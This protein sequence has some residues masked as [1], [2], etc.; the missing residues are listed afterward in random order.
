MITDIGKQLNLPSGMR[1]ITTSIATG[2]SRR[3]SETYAVRQ[4][5][6]HLFGTGSILGHRDDGSPVIA[7]SKTEISVSHSRTHAFLASHPDL[8]I[9]VD[10]EL[11]RQQLAIVARK[12]LSDEELTAW[13]TIDHL[14]TAWTIKEAVYKAAGTPGLP[15]AGIKLP[16][17]HV[18][19][20]TIPDGRRFR[21]FTKHIAPHT[22]TVAIPL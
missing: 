13:V 8:R 4:L 18:T 1:L 10:A 11:P 22:I 20:A 16:T 19:E 3:E 12:F 9:G 7:G 14:L 5:V 21:L 15:L 6:K 17:R 2:T